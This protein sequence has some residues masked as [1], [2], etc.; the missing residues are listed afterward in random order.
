MSGLDVQVVG[1]LIVITDPK[2]EFY[3]VY[4][5][6]TDEPHLHLRGRAETT[7][8]ALLARVCQAAIDTARELGWIV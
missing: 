5:K 6:P 1:G 4:D 2:T 3:A 8:Q 7:D